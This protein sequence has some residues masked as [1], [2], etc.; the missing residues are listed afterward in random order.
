[1]SKDFTRI[2]T[3]FGLYERFQVEGL[4]ALEADLQRMEKEMASELGHRAVTKAMKPT[5]SRV[6]NNLSSGAHSANKSKK[7]GKAIVDTG[8][9]LRSVEQKPATLE[10]QSYRKKSELRSYV[11]AGKG[12]K[13]GAYKTGDR[14]G[15]R[16]PIYALQ[17]EYGTENSAFGVLPEQPFMRPAFDGYERSIA[18]DLKEALK[19]TIVKWKTTSKD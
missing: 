18:D 8:A 14:K 19:Q 5:L 10:R 15:M 17:V 11:I 13:R 2:R 3:R 9:L 16:K 6:K 12:G 7:G 4:D 1:M